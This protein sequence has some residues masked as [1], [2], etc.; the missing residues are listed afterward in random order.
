MLRVLNNSR[1]KDKLSTKSM[2]T[3]FGLLSVNQLAAKIKLIE[4]WKITNREKYPLTL[5]NYNQGSIS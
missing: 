3:K 5:E 4:V 1:I 2:L